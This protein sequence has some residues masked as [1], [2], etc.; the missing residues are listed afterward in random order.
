MSQEKQEVMEQRVRDFI[1]DIRA[2]HPGTI[3]AML[4]PR[5]VSC[6]AGEQSIL[7]AFP[8]QAWEAN[9]LGVMQGGI[10]ATMLDFTVAALA[11]CFAGDAPMTVSLQVSYLRGTPVKGEMMVRARATK[12]GRQVVHALAECWNSEEPGKLTATASS[13]CLRT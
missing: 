6:D 8:A 9:P 3:I 12:A 13:A 7:L 11:V 1:G 10:V 2:N 4:E 5:F